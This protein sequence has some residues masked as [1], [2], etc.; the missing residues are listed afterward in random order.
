MANISEDEKEDNLE[1]SLT[2]DNKLLSILLEKDT[3]TIDKK[4]YK[5]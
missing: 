4:I 3:T 5:A 2:N 1:N